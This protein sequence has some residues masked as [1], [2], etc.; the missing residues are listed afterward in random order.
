MWLPSASSSPLGPSPRLSSCPEP[1]RLTP[2]APPHQ[3]GFSDS[4]SCCH[5]LSQPQLLTVRL[6]LALSV[7]HSLSI[8]SASDLIFIFLSIADFCSIAESPACPGLSVTGRLG[9]APPCPVSHFLMH[10]LSLLLP[11]TV[12]L[13][14]SLSMSLWMPVPVSPSLPVSSLLCCVSASPHFPYT[15]H[16]GPLSLTVHT[17]THTHTHT[18]TCTHPCSFTGC[19]LGTFYSRVWHCCQIG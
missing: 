19:G 17:H 13:I 10:C 6:P 3:P 16:L 2:Q 14:L 18:C 11:F 8:A 1:L 7:S 5:P 9:R 15:M 4:F 12:P